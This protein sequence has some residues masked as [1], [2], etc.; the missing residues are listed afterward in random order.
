M[1][2]KLIN[3]NSFYIFQMNS[4]SLGQKLGFLGQKLECHYAIFT[5]TDKM[6][7]VK[8]LINSSGINNWLSLRNRIFKSQLKIKT[9][10]G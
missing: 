3:I 1:S 5:C 10:N 9:K 8:I 7:V 2:W 6:G 4:D